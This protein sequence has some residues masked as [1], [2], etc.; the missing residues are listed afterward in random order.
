[1]NDLPAKPDYR[2]VHWDAELEHHLRQLIRL[3]VLEDLDRYH[4][5]TT[6]ALVA[7]DAEATAAVVSREQGRLAGLAAIPVMLDEMNT[8]LTWEPG[9][10]DGEPLEAGQ[11]LG[12]LSG[13]SRDLLVVERP[14]LNLVAR[15]S[16]IATLTRQFVDEV[17]TSEVRIY[18]TRKTTP[19]WRRLEKYAVRCGGGY[20]HRAG[21]FDGI[22]VKDNHLATS[23]GE[24]PA[25][26]AAALEKVRAFIDQAQ[27][28]YPM[29]EN[30]LVEVEVDTLEQL[31]DVLPA[32]PDIVLLDN[33]SAEMLRE[34]VACRNQLSPATE[35]E[36][37]GG[38]T[39]GQLAAIAESG[40]ERISAGA[41]THSA[42]ALDIGLDWLDGHQAD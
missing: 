19:G 32:N 24:Q 11:S 39:L 22:L 7:A 42:T 40:V 35:L 26:P 27:D 2:Q 36:A 1:M 23:N 3:A 4:D 15:L 29:L 17:A 5:W 6:L 25:S 21:L 14:L 33:M 8:R 18:D 38:V 34:A 10:S 28:E 30:L 13:S 41:L 9:A 12:T 16:G 37:S 31:A 20:N